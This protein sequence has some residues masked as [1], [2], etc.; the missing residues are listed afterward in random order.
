MTISPAPR[1][2]RPPERIVLVGFMGAG[3]STVGP[4]LAAR[5]GWQFR[6]LDEWIEAQ[7]GARV[8]DLFRDR[9][10]PFFREAERQAA[11]VA[12]T[13]RHHVIA[14]GGGAFTQ[15]AT[16]S[17]LRAGAV[18]V[19][20][21]CDLDTVVARIPDDG[22]RP[23]ASNRERMTVLLA[24][25]EASYRLADLTVDTTDGPPEEIARRI[26]EAIFGAESVGTKADR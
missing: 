9:G 16:R 25:R 14:T 23:L 18:A 6:D 1:F 24:E 8:A 10:E 7:H 3:K 26:Q 17:A 20:L 11:D 19:W 4:L 2:A 21:R 12:G 15:E 22:S 5:L 13:L